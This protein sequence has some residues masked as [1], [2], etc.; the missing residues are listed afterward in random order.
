MAA[1]RIIP[2]VVVL[3][4]A[5]ILNFYCRFKTLPRIRYTIVKCITFIVKAKFLVCFTS[6]E[7]SRYIE[8]FRKNNLLNPVYQARKKKKKS[9]DTIWRVN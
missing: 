1:W 4:Y 6:F 9:D 2:S 7:T 8:Q 5:T 3:D